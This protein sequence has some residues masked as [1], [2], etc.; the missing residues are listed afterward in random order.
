[1]D[2]QWGA[3][4]SKEKN[5]PDMF[6]GKHFEELKNGTTLELEG[7][8]KW[9]P[10][11]QFVAEPDRAKGPPNKQ[12][13]SAFTITVKD[14]GSDST[15]EMTVD[16]DWIDTTVGLQTGALEKVETALR[17]AD[18]TNDEA[19]AALNKLTTFGQ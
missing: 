4:F 10:R 15:R 7:G 2:C 5:K 14:K 1:M 17:G 12:T 18:M 11:E 16:R 8:K 9:V 19:Q 13:K 6:C 3:P